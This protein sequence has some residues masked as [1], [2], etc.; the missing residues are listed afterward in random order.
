MK[1]LENGEIRSGTHISFSSLYKLVHFIVLL[2]LYSVFF[3]WFLSS[4][5]MQV[6]A[7]FEVVTIIFV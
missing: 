2:Q 3:V 1:L 6:S 4:P 7:S 5:K